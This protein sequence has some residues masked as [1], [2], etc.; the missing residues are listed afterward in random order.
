MNQ[1]W[2]TLTNIQRVFY[3]AA[4]PA[5]LILFIQTL[6][7]IFGL[8]GN[9]DA[10]VDG[11]S[12]GNFDLS[13]NVS[14]GYEAPMDAADGQIGEFSPA[15][16]DISNDNMQG[17]ADLRFFSI[18]G[19]VAFFTI[20]GWVGVVLSQNSEM[21]NILVFFIAIICGT[22]AMVLIAYMFYGITKLQY[23]GNVSYKNALGKIG[24]VYIPIPA[25]REGTGKI[26][27]TVQ[28][29]LIEADA[30]TDE[31]ERIPTGATIIV[32][33]ILSGNKMLVRQHKHADAKE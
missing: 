29:R 23:S 28:E 5:T 30:V 4:I 21:S 31:T 27:V 3:I 25:I 26:Q 12:S 7:T 6:F 15:Y 32:V 13:D 11:G 17:A 8:A 19:I 1:W 16:T 9:M 2:E 18:R 20:F 24:E 33:G 22:A 10:D 14:G